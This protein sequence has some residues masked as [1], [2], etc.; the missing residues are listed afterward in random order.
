MKKFT[1]FYTLVSVCVCLSFF[2]ESVELNAAARLD[3]DG[4]PSG[5]KRRHPGDGPDADRDA[6][7]RRRLDEPAR[8]GAAAPAAPAEDKP[9]DKPD[10]KVE[11]KSEEKPEEK[12]EEEPVIK[13]TDCPICFEACT[14]VDANDDKLLVGFGCT[15]EFCYACIKK[16]IA[17]KEECP[18]CRRKIIEA[19]VE[20]RLYYAQWIRAIKTDDSLFVKDHINDQA[21][22]KSFFRQVLPIHR[23]IDAKAVKILDFFKTFN[24]EN[25][26][27]VN[28][29]GLSFIGENAFAVN[30]D[31]LSFIGYAF[32]HD[33]LD[34]VDTYLSHKDRLFQY[35]HY[36]PIADSKDLDVMFEKR[37]NRFINII[38]NRGDYKVRDKAIM[39][40]IEHKNFEMLESVLIDDIKSCGPEIYRI[41]EGTAKQLLKKDTLIRALKSGDIKIIRSLYTLFKHKLNQLIEVQNAYGK[42]TPILDN[43]FAKTI[44][45]CFAYLAPVSSDEDLIKER[46]KMLFQEFIAFAQQ[47]HT[48]LKELLPSL[49]RVGEIEY[50]IKVEKDFE[51]YA[52]SLLSYAP[53]QL[54]SIIK[55]AKFTGIDTK[56]LLE[57]ALNLDPAPVDKILVLLHEI[58]EIDAGFFTRSLGDARETILHKICKKK[59][60]AEPEQQVLFDDLIYLLL[61][62]GANPEI[63][64]ILGR[65]A[66]VP[67]AVKAR[68]AEHQA[69][70]AAEERIAQEARAAKAAALAKKNS[71]CIIC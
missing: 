64:D 7:M 12:P 1:L 60:S 34:F 39:L 45:S 51:Q 31:G 14:D 4:V 55:L 66:D 5:I 53:E 42:W 32:K 35:Q 50:I 15:H 67:E 33:L 26:S 30:H 27:A 54:A 43:D 57:I 25:A 68:F 46:K 20:K 2:S 49:F 28:H 69:K 8:P 37:A 23:A 65:Q 48:S 21:A 56:R 40:S 70:A 9:A 61:T 59:N 41:F 29:D 38:Y 71:K 36:S 62:F 22:N 18:T 44:L 17:R 3:R 63:H 24:N 47:V 10:S 16:A 13:T 58:K 6:A 11:A 19:A 52:P